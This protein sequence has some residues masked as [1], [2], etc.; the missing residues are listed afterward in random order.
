MKKKKHYDESIAQMVDATVK[1]LADDGYP[2]LKRNRR[3]TK[4]ELKK[5]IKSSP[6]AFAGAPRSWL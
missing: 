5:L 4:K 3:K 1:N 6:D 2:L